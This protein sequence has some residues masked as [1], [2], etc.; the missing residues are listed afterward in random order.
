MD[1][2][3]QATKKNTKQGKNLGEQQLE[4]NKLMDINAPPSQSFI[5]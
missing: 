2:S 1:K 5:Q 4:T 3:I